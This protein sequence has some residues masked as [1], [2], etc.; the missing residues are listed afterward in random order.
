[1]CTT[2]LQFKPGKANQVKASLSLQVKSTKTTA[3][4]VFHM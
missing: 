2:G 4:K 1:M 3:I